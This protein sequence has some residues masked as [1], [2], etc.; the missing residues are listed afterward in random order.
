MGPPVTHFPS[1]RRAGTEEGVSDPMAAPGSYVPDGDGRI[2]HDLAC[3]RCAYNLRTLRADGVCPECGTAIARSLHGQ[4]LAYADPDWVARLA[5]GANW[6]VRG[7]NCILLTLILALV[8]AVAIGLTAS[9]ATPGPTVIFSPVVSAS[10]IGLLLF[11]AVSLLIGYW[12]LTLPDPGSPDEDQD[13]RARRLGRTGLIGA[14]GVGVMIGPLARILPNPVAVAAACGVIAAGLLIVG[15][16]GFF[17]Y[18]ARLGERI[19]DA[20]LTARSRSV[21]KGLVI[22]FGLYL[23]I[24]LFNL[25]L[26]R[27]IVRGGAL[28]PGAGMGTVGADLVS[29]LVSLFLLVY[30]NRALRLLTGFRRQLRV[31]LGQARRN[32]NE[33][34]PSTAPVRPGTG[35]CAGAR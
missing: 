7:I 3:V 22:C 14:L 8:G 24:A 16:F 27:F 10:A 35:G 28:A 20:N 19:P 30:L 34:I 4:L 21:G 1:I 5:R 11:G 15:C 26:V 32:W 12:W 9:L 17:G 6:T 31:V 29:G 33:V 25:V 18:L 23:A 2:A 13:Q